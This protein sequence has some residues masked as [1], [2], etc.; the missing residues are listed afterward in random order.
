MHFESLQKWKVFKIF[1]KMIWWP[2]SFSRNNLCEL[3][4]FWVRVVMAGDL[5]VRFLETSLIYLP[6]IRTNFWLCVS[7]RTATDNSIWRNRFFQPT[8]FILI[9]KCDWNLRKLLGVSR[10][11]CFLMLLPPPRP[12]LGIQDVIGTCRSNFVFTTMDNG[13]KVQHIVSNVT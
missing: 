9:I 7:L 6:N 2:T 5:F 3:G 13:L 1:V 4:Q 11:S 10:N 8:S 12:R